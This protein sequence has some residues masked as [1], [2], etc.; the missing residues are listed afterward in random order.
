MAHFRNRFSFCH[1]ARL[2]YEAEWN[3]EISGRRCAAKLW[4][5]A[6]GA[7]DLWLRSAR[8]KGIFGS[9]DHRYNSWMDDYDRLLVIDDPRS[10]V[11]FLSEPGSKVNLLT[12]GWRWR[13][14][15][16][17]VGEAVGGA[18]RAAERA[19]FLL[20]RAGLADVDGVGLSRL[21]LPSDQPGRRW[22]T[23]GVAASR[24]R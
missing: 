16:K 20:K 19:R 13:E 14:T 8:D 11:R 18:E 1:P 22:W 2:S 6:D 4:R 10:I 5:Y 15:D 3:L 7:S 17:D 24:E 21:V 23:N 9:I 12:E